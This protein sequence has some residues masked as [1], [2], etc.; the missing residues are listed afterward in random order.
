MAIIAA[1]FTIL[2]LFDLPRFLKNKE[3]AKVIIIY[4]F[5]IST[6]LVISMLLA[7]GKRPPSPAEWI[8]WILKTIGV[9]K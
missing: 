6:S 7:A 3:P 8:E 4:A 9:I 1:V 5:F 2:V